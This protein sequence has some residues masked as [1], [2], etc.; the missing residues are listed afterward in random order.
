[1]AEDSP[2]SAWIQWK[3]ITLSK[4]RKMDIPLQDFFEWLQYTCTQREEKAIKTLL[5]IDKEFSES[6]LKMT[7]IQL[8]EQGMISPL[9]A[10]ETAKKCNVP[11]I[12]IRFWA[13]KLWTRI[14]REHRRNEWLRTFLDEQ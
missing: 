5:D 8:K 12:K 4:R 1:M 14:A 2:A 11:A 13:K 10:E 6:E 3:S 7:L 9:T